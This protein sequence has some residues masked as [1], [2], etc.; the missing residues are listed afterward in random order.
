MNGKNVCI[1]LRM[2]DLLRP[3][4]RGANDLADEI[5][6]SILALPNL[7]NF[8]GDRPEH[9]LSLPTYIHAIGT[10]HA[11]CRVVAVAQVS[12][13]VGIRVPNFDLRKM[14]EVCFGRKRAHTHTHTHTHTLTSRSEAERGRTG[15]SE[16][17]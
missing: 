4:T 9:E 1:C 11:A 3:S 14:C 17:G 2:C 5:K 16:G 10:W 7:R 15:R 12:L 8:L 6:K 13:L